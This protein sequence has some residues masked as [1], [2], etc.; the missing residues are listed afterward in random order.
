MKLL[1]MD[2]HT[3]FSQSVAPKKI[4]QATNNGIRTFANVKCRRMSEILQLTLII[5][6][7]IRSV[8]LKQIS[9]KKSTFSASISPKKLR[10][11]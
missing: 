1:K 11:S 4:K 7:L 5:G 8:C 6:S 3:N 9:K 2:W 10:G